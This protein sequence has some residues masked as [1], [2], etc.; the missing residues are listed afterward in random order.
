M[1]IKCL[2]NEGLTLYHDYGTIHYNNLKHKGH[3][4]NST[5]IEYDKMFNR[6]RDLTRELYSQ[7]FL[8]EDGP[9]G[10]KT[11]DILNRAA[12]DLIIQCR[13]EITRLCNVP[14]AWLG[15]DLFCCVFGNLFDIGTYEELQVYITMRKIE[16]EVN[17]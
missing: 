10:S 4:M 5:K 3:N 7:A 15:N 13:D 2:S 12:E 6:Y 11:S 1:F 17:N 9:Q 8:F 14:F 16:A